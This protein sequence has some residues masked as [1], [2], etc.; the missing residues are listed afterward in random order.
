M[1]IITLPPGAPI[2]CCGPP[3]TNCPC[4]RLTVD[5]NDVPETT[6]AAAPTCQGETIEAL[7]PE[8]DVVRLW[9]YVNDDPTTNVK[10]T[11][12]W[13]DQYD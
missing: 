11:Y 4:W 3:P 13:I 9:V 1:D 6:V 5:G 8:F 2:C 10:H 12:I 7:Y